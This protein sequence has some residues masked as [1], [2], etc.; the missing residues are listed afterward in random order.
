MPP[1]NPITRIEA[2]ARDLGRLAEELADYAGPDARTALL[3]WQSELLAAVDHVQKTTTRE[4]AG[5]PPTEA[6]GARE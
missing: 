2:V 4:T 1:Q 6:S 5:S 3:Y